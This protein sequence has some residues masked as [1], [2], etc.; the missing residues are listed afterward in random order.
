M[1]GPYRNRLVDR[2]AP[3]AF[4]GEVHDVKDHP[5]RLSVEM[6]IEEPGAHYA[7]RNVVVR[8]PAD[9]VGQKVTDVA[10]VVA[11]VAAI[12]IGRQV[13]DTRSVRPLSEDQAGNIGGGLF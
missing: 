4:V 9:D 5:R 6:T 7:Q 2:A 3:G 10:N 12:E 8:S 13:R 1:D 11:R